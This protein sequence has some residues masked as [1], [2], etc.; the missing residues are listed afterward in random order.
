MGE[1]LARTSYVHRFGILGVLLVS[2]IL[3]ISG[4]TTGS[5]SIEEW[6]YFD[7]FSTDKA[8]SDSYSHSPFCLNPPD[9]GG[10]GFLMYV[11]HTPDER[12]LGFFAGFWVSDW[13]ATLNYE[14]PLEYTD[15][16]II[17]GTLELD[18]GELDDRSGSLSV[19]VSYVGANGGFSERVTEIGHFEYSLEPEGVAEAVRVSFS[20]AGVS[21][22]N[23]QVSLVGIRRFGGA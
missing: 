22:D 8:A 5:G 15:L 20:G 14:F 12:S 21:L 19:A 17:G 6:R 13:E 2:L 16:V 9:A 10:P 4:C 7:A 23:L 1:C 3:F 18:V 11:L